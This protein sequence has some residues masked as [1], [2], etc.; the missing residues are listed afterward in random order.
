[1]KFIE[2]YCAIVNDGLGRRVIKIG[3]ENGF[4]SF[5]AFRGK[6]TA[7]SRIANILG[8]EDVRKEITVFAA[9]KA[10]GDNAIKKVFNR[11]KLHKPNRG[12]CFSLPL[13]Q[14][15]GSENHNYKSKLSKNEED[16]MEYKLI[17]TI[18]E[19]GNG[20]EVVDAAQKAGAKGATIINARGSGVHETKKVFN[21]EIEPEKEVV[22]VLAKANLT[23]KIKDTISEELELDKPGHGIVFILNVSDTYG[24]YDEE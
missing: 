22:L 1:M 13:E 8:I 9:E 14:I 20:E 23:N 16:K 17:I 3:R 7:R 15:A 21:I 24:L 12:I 19:R 2:L 10:I 11:L 18:V 6:G 4:E 5:T